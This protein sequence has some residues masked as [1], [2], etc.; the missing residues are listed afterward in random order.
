MPTKKDES[1]A[2]AFFSSSSTVF[3]QSGHTQ[4]GNCKIKP[5]FWVVSFPWSYKAKY[6]A[7]HRECPTI[8]KHCCLYTFHTL[9]YTINYIYACLQGINHEEMLNTICKNCQTILNIIP[10]RNKF[11]MIAKIAAEQVASLIYVLSDFL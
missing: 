11:F 5:R 7:S 6:T 3:R 1:Y 4:S 8:E 2:A 10:F 9:L